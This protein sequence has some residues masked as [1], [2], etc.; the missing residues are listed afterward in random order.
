MP[1]EE[2]TKAV[3]QV[4]PPSDV[5]SFVKE[6]FDS[7]SKT[8]QAFLYF[9][10]G[11]LLGVICKR[12][13]KYILWGVVV[14]FIVVKWLE[15]RHAI[16]VNWPGLYTTI[17]LGPT[18]DIHAMSIRMFEWIKVNWINAIAITVGFL[19]GFKPSVAPKGVSIKISK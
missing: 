16:T 13:L 10:A 2:V 19:L 17:G 7:P 6:V 11:L 3:P 9:G 15:Y 1:L 14:A 5:D 8:V 4:A 12:Y 18:P